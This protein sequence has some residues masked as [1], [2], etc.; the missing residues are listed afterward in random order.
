MRNARGLLAVFEHPDDLIATARKIHGLRITKCDAYTPFAVHGLDQAM[1][2]KRS[3]IPWATLI[4]AVSGWGLGFLFQIW[5][6]NSGW[7]VNVGGKPKGMLGW[8]AFIPI[9]F[10]AMVLLAG[11]STALILLGMCWPFDF[12]RR[13]YDPRLTD[14][15]FGFFVASDDPHFNETAL[16]N[17]FKEH[18]AED[19]RQIV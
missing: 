14:D 17:I 18:H 11:V 2:I 9:S 7:P 3:W 12:W 15:R 1:G 6:H 8:P 16:R 4:I 10:E 5:T 19:V 13:H